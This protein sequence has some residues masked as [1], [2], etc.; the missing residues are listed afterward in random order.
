MMHDS[1]CEHCVRF[2]GCYMQVKC[3][4][5][6]DKSGYELIV[7]FLLVDLLLLSNNFDLQMIITLKQLSF[8]CPFADV[9]DFILFQGNSRRKRKKNR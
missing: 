6:K 4:G 9:V 7:P 8:L 3:E 5:E 2:V 1:F